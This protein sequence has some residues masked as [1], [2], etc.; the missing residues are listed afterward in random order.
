M[1]LYNVLAYGYEFLSE[2]VPFFVMLILF[3]QS[4]G[5]YAVHFSKRHYVFPVVF[6]LYIIAVYHV[7]GAGT[8]YD[9]ITAQFEDMK[10]RINL[11]P[12]SNKNNATGYMLNIVMFVPFGFLIPLIWKRTGNVPYIILAGFMF[13]LLIEVSQLFSYRGTDVDDLIL[14]TF[15]AVLGFILYR[16]FEKVCKIKYQLD[17]IDVKE[18]PAYI[19]IIY[20]GRFL[21]FNQLGLINLVY[22]Y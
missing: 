10:E 6:A 8:I 17:D 18:L 20:L 15:G 5:K 7:T 19:L 13:S 3:R 16:A 9:L 12:F 21:L 22:G 2:F 11:I 14:N 1:T 4:R